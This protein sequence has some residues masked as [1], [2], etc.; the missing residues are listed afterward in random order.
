[1]TVSRSAYLAGIVRLYLDDPDTPVVPSSADWDI[2]ADLYNRGVPMENV[3]IAFKIAFIRRHQRSSPKLLPPIR[4][5]AY[6]RTVTINLTVEETEPAYVEY[7]DRL[8][9]RLLPECNPI[10][11]G[12]SDDRS[13]ASIPKTAP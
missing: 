2:A 10:N 3:C 5:L 12:R 9:T 11:P 13:V 6:F 8:Y 4:S 7:I 1:M